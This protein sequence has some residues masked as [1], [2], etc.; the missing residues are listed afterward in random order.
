[1]INFSVNVTDSKIKVSSLDGSAFRADANASSL[2]GSVIELS[3]VF[4]EDLLVLVSGS[5][6][7]K[8]GATYDQ[9]IAIDE[10][11]EYRVKIENFEGTKLEIFDLQGIQ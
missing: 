2:V 10:E 6:A 4:Q 11:N 5:G 1:M 9:V 3:N 8:L 7:R